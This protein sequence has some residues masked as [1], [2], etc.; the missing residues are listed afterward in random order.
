MEGTCPE[1]KLI[2]GSGSPEGEERTTHSLGVDRRK[3]GKE[4]RKSLSGKRGGSRRGL[5]LKKKRRGGGPIPA[6]DTQGREGP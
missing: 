4:K 2:K 1:E 5:S 3:K 6:E